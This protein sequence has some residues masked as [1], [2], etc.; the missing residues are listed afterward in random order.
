[1]I[2]IKLIREIIGK[3]LIKEYEKNMT[4]QKNSKKYLKKL[5]I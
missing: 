3:N 4:T 5:K 1:M 2:K